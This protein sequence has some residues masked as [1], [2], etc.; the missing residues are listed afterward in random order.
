M[1]MERLR[2]EADIDG[3][4]DAS[5]P[6]SDPPN[7]TLGREPV[8]PRIGAP[9]TA[10]A[11]AEAV[12]SGTSTDGAGTLNGASGCLDVRYTH[13]AGGESDARGTNPEEL[14]GAALAGGFS[15]FLAARLEAAG[16][17]P[18]RIRT[19]ATVHLDAGPTIVRI[20]LATEAEV[21]GLDEKRF[22]EEVAASVRDSPIAKA[23]SALP[24]I[25]VG[26]RLV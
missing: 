22:R 9:T 15:T 13:S 17:A 8:A 7:W 25:T 6:A 11:R 16:F 5:F 1:T 14:L 4:L 18:T 2:S 21:P 24:S 10:V 12:W 19:T 23:L 26:A 3:T 20:E